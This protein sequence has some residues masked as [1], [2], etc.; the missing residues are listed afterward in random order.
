MPSPAKPAPTISTDTGLAAA[1]RGAVFLVAAFFVGALR[2]AFL[3]AAFFATA[4]FATAF[5]A[6]A[7][8]ATVL[9]DAGFFTAVLFS[10]VGC[11]C[12]PIFSSRMFSSRLLIADPSA[13]PFNFSLSTFNSFKPPAY[14]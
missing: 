13:C 3:P 11:S 8:L 7:F 4:F 9:P 6:G 14:T 2:G 12:P 5:L 1:W 10:G